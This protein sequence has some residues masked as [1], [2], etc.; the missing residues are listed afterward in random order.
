MLLPLNIIL[1]RPTHES[2]NWL[3]GLERAGYSA[4]NW[5]LIEITPINPAESGKDNAQVFNKLDTFDAMVFVSSAAVEHFFHALI[6]TQG[7][8]KFQA[9]CSK[10]WATGPGTAQALL[11]HGVPESQIVSPP[12]NAAQFDSPQL[13]EISKHLLKPGE[14]VLFVRGLDQPT[15]R[16]ASL[17]HVP[18]TDKAPTGSQWLMSQLHQS[19][20]LV[21]EIAVY[22]RSAPQWS[23]EQKLKIQQTFNAQS[24]WIFSS[25]LSLEH[26]GSLLPHQD[27]SKGRSIATHDRIAQT[28][29]AMGWGVVKASRP[30][31]SDVL[32]S[33]KSFN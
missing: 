31:L 15:T 11:K 28:A 19:G 22:K 4:V 23:E 2:L 18:A 14:R 27:W 30:T 1:T 16:A 10:C 20:V 3:E 24:I 13:W 5:P 7:L 33:L 32:T 6:Q 21:S 8:K 12:A 9:Q 29:V 25:S 26:L 17:Q